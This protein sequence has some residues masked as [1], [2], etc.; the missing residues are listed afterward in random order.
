M[1]ALFQ[2]LL[3]GGGMGGREVGKP[4]KPASTTVIENRNEIMTFKLNNLTSQQIT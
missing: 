1:N 2:V 3:I 4:A